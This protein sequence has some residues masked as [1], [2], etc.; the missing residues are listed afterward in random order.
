[1]EPINRDRICILN[2]KTAD[3]IIV[4]GGVTGLSVALHLK[5]R[6]AGK[7]V[8]LERHHVAA[9]Q[10][11]HAAGIV[12]GLVGHQAVASMLMQSLR[13]FTSFEDEYQ[14]KLAVHPV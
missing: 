14:E 3:F 6:N 5:K 9:G 13:F 1:M 4:G 8:L 11:G 2:G 12:R 10:A 7:V